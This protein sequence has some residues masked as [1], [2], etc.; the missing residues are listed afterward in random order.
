MTGHFTAKL[1]W[2]PPAQRAV[3]A[4]LRRVAALGWVL[5]GGTAIALRLGHRVSVD[6][7]FF[8]D[9]PLDR[10]GLFGACPPLNRAT[11]LQD[12]PNTLTVLMSPVD[13]STASVK[14][15]FFGGLEFGRVGVP[16]W[17]DDGM[18]QVASLDDLLA[19]KLKVLL[20]RVD[21]KDYLDVAALIESGTRLDRGLA[22]AKA[23]FGAT[24]QPSESLKALVY[25]EGGD[26]ATL[27]AA[28]KKGLI[29]A[30]ASVRALPRID[31]LAPELALPS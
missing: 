11:V 1:G 31:T 22:S 23:L 21:A 17:T 18:L 26:L 19:H 4:E 28:V 12:R 16:E 15:S 5:Y 7:D 14:V 20:Q 3:W 8:N 13:P 6:F 9:R 29:L 27:P 30:A 25:F 2:L 24:F 10:E